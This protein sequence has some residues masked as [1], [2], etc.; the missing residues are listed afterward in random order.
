MGTRKNVG[1][2]FT[3][4]ATQKVLGQGSLPQTSQ[5]VAPPPPPILNTSQQQV[6]D[7]SAEIVQQRSDIGRIRRG[8]RSRRRL[9]LG[10]SNSKNNL[11]GG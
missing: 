2:S 5:I 8:N 4:R 7:P 11:L 6:V 10:P 1:P 3:Q 9:L